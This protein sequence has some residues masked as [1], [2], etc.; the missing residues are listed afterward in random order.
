MTATI[1]IA[2]EMVR[3]YETGKSGD[4]VPTATVPDLERACRDLC[5]KVDMW[6]ESEELVREDA[7]KI[8]YLMKIDAPRAE[9]DAVA[10][11]LK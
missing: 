6:L 1:D 2:R 10:A 9:L 5:D 3:F 4:E 7:E 8:V 11:R